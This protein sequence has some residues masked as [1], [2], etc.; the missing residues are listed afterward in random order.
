MFL[1]RDIFYTF[2]PTTKMPF[3]YTLKCF[4]QQAMIMKSIYKQLKLYIRIVIGLLMLVELRMDTELRSKARLFYG[5]TTMNL[6]YYLDF[7]L[8]YVIWWSYMV[9]W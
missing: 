5:K 2:I 6:V 3:L 9:L 1:I 4:S 8:A 7:V